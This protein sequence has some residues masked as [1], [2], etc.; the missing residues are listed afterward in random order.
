MTRTGRADLSVYL[1]TDAA[2][3]RA[4]GRTVV[5]TVDAA[6][7]GG[8]TCVQVR[9]KDGSG[10]DFLD[11][12]LRVAERVGD[13]ATVLVNDRVDVYLAARR[14]DPRVH[15]VHV[16]Q[17]DL[18]VEAVRDMV[19]RDAIVGLSAATPEELE[20]AGRSAASVDYVGIGA[21]H[22]T[23]TK[24]DAPQTLGIDGFADRARLTPLPAVAI[25]GVGVADMAPL[26]AAGAAGGAVVSAIC[27]APD[28]R[29]AAG[30]LARA[31]SGT[32]TPTAA[33]HRDQT[34]GE[35]R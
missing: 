32:S 16:G 7:A 35:S 10:R 15:G 26:R 31:W 20:R 25:G 23:S 33:E 30:D 18:P 8:A 27:A 14:S 1:V 34:R 9:Q 5:D 19:G 28:P 4:A 22:S 3:C 24:G 12:V 2:Q 6:V 21:L 13:R 29:R 11:T 17:D